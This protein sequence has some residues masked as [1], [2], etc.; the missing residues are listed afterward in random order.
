MKKL[1]IL[2]AVAV[3]LTVACTKKQTATHCYVC[4]STDTLDAWNGY[5]ACDMTEGQATTFMLLRTTKG[6]T[7]K[8]KIND[9]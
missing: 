5:N 3:V 4:T 8:C 9:L 2:S 7:T 6:D 1:F